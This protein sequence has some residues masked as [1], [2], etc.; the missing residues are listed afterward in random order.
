MPEYYYS[1]VGFSYTFGNFK[2]HTRESSP[3]GT[4]LFTSFAHAS[5]VSAITFKAYS[6]SKIHPNSFYYSRSQ[7][8]KTTIRS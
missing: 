8:L 3:A 5:F 4:D 2:V 6:W 1:K 7:H